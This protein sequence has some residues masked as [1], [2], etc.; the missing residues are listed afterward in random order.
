[1]TE[2]QKRKDTWSLK[3]EQLLAEVVLTHIR[4]GSSQLNAFEEVGEQL[5]RSS[6]ACGFRWNSTIRKLYEVEIKAAKQLRFSRKTGMK[7]DV[8][9]LSEDPASAY[10]TSNT[11]GGILPYQPRDIS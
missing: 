5:S 3:D 9:Q 2:R 11:T 10:E 4:E 8:R 6:A 1:M 7:V